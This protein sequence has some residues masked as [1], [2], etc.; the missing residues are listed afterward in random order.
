MTKKD[1]NYR[2]FNNRTA[3]DGRALKPGDI[4]VPVVFIPIEDVPGALGK[5]MKIFNSEVERY[6]KH[7][8]DRGLD[9]ISLDALMQGDEDEGGYDPTGTTDNEDTAFLEQIFK[10]LISDLNEQ[11]PNMGRII[12]LLAEGYKK[13]EI[14]ELVDLDKG[15]SQTYE[16]ITKTQKIAAKIY[17]ERYGM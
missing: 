11:D 9:E 6:L 3:F 1:S 15:R 14:F 5:A 8:D 16:F 13:N 17:S 10:M 7:M 2:N 4:L 12:E